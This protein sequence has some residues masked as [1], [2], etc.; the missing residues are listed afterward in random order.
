[1]MGKRSAFLTGLTVIATAVTLTACG[2]Q[3]GSKTASSDKA[4][5]GKVTA[6]G[7]TALQPLVEQ[8]AKDFQ[9]KNPNV[10]VNVQGGGSG[11]GLSQ[12]AQGAVDIGN[13]DIFA[14]SKPCVATDKITEHK[15]AVI[16][17]APVVNPDIKIKKLTMAQLQNI[18]AGKVINWK[19]VGGKD[20]KIV[21]VNRATGSGTR[22]TFDDNVMKGK[23]S[24]KSQEQDSSGAVQKIVGSTP[25][26]ISY[27]AFSYLTKNLQA[28]ALDGVAPT[29]ANVL[30]NKWKIWSYE[31]MYTQKKASKA[32]V[33]FIKF[34]NSDHVQ[35]DLVKKLGYISI[36]DM[37][38]VKDAKG[39]V[40]NK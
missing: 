27:L 32:A 17:F 38:V 29:T 11:T 6:V 16:G 21:L 7:S 14:E 19:Q 20:E 13:S 12:V 36:K 31:H 18:F 30:N 37:Q 4:L 2:G 5:S 9:A 1:M 40:T 10:T 24:L 22:A 25:G 8:A 33:A 23:K 39:N 15:V 34:M 28:V 3:S 26:A 35:G